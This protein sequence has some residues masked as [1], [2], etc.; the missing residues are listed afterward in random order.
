MLK[1][2][3]FEQH[4]HFCPVNIFLSFVCRVFLIFL[5]YQHGISKV[6]L[7]LVITFMSSYCRISLFSWA[8]IA[9]YE[10]SCAGDYFFMSSFCRIFS[11]SWAPIAGYQHSCAGD[12]L[13]PV[14]CGP[15]HWHLH[16]T[17]PGTQGPRHQASPCIQCPCTSRKN[18]R[19]QTKQNS[20]DSVPLKGQCQENFILTE[21]VGV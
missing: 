2:A 11:L 15:L 18:W 1:Y 7:V 8:P 19:K 21:T 16:P 10:H 20:C 5:T 14:H 13:H 12:H 4:H 17:R 3:Q 9:G 6:V